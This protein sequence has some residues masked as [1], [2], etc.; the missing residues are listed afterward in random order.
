MN[1]SN[2]RYNLSL[3]RFKDNQTPIDL[4]FFDIKPP[5]KEV[6]ILRMLI[7][8]NGNDFKIPE[9]YKWIE[10]AVYM[11]HQHIKNIIMIDRRFCY[12][13][14]RHGYVKSVTDD[15]WH[16]DG[17]SMRKPVRPEINYVYASNNPT[18]FVTDGFD[19]PKDFDPLV[20]NLDQYFNDN[21]G[22]RKIH[23]AK[24]KHI[25]AFD[26]YLVHRRP[27]LPKNT[28]RTFF[29]ISFI[30][31]EIKD[32]TCTENPLLPTTKYPVNEFKKTLKIYKKEAR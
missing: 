11:C 8:N 28:W 4:G 17:F 27:I 31:I 23:R 19:I 2:F 10:R 3:S 1:T 29:R 9:E 12:L 24:E 21:I 6:Y 26:T 25:Y 5:S 30:E 20:Y 16:A 18:E 13:T 7:S 14:I 22:E 32:G 15:I